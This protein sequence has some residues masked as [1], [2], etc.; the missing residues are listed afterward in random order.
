VDPVPD[1]LLVRKS[2]SAGNRTRTSESEARNSDTRPQRRTLL[3]KKGL[4]CLDV[5]LE[6]IDRVSGT[7]IGTIVLS[8]NFRHIR[9]CQDLELEFRWVCKLEVE[10]KYEV[11]AGNW[12]CS[13]HRSAD[14]RMDSDH[15]R[16]SQMDFHVVIR[17]MTLSL[18][19]ADNRRYSRV[20]SLPGR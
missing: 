6:D 18:C 17:E 9:C 16:A 12:T 8:T 3:L 15:N 7:C 20:G 19:D 11:A 13:C 5:V 4:S 1:S 10:L 2:G 14:R